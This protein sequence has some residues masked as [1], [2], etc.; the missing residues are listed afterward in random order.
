MAK[1]GSQIKQQQQQ[2]ARRKFYAIEK[3]KEKINTKHD[4]KLSTEMNI[5]DTPTTA[6]RRYSATAVFVIAV[7]IRTKQK[8]L[9]KAR[10]KQQKIN[11]RYVR[12]LTNTN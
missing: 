3:I 6:S 4:D 10:Q 12:T 8:F 11:A 2:N 7:L 9:Q 1:H 5:E